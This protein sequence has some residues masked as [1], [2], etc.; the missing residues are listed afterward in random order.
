PR[1][2]QERRRPDRHHVDLREGQASQARDQRPVAG[3]FVGAGEGAGAGSLPASIASSLRWCSRKRL[4]WSRSTSSIS[5]LLRSRIRA[6]SSASSRS[7]TPDAAKSSSTSTLALVPSLVS[8]VTRTWFLPSRTGTKPEKLP[9]GRRF[10]SVD[11][12]F[13]VRLVSTTSSTF[14]NDVPC[15]NDTMSPGFCTGRNVPSVIREISVA[16]NGL[17]S[18]EGP[19]A[20]VLIA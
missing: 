15:R 9:S 3:A 6:S 1:G 12:S 19:S 16:V 18:A 4:M 11:T 20:Y 17:V 8:A 13:V 10:T 5:S 7:D 14:A 2:R